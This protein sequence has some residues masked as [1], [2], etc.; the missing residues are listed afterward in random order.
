M[1]K[2]LTV[3]KGI[4]KPPICACG[5]RQ[6]PSPLGLAAWLGRAR[7]VG[8]NRR[9]E[10]PRVPPNLLPSGSDHEARKSGRAPDG[11]QGGGG[12]GINGMGIAN[13]APRGWRPMRSGCEPVTQGDRPDRTKPEPEH[14]QTRRLRYRSDAQSLRILPIQYIMVIPCRPCRRGES[15]IAG[16]LA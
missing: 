2:P 9:P 15:N 14:Q 11:D 8:G 3:T 5:S 12:R 13:R 7:R 10:K 16:I 4:P 6:N 1:L